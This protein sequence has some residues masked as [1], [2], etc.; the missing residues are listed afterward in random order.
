MAQAG[1]GRVDGAQ[2]TLPET[3]AQVHVYLGSA[4]AAPSLPEAVRTSDAPNG[5]KWI[6]NDRVRLLLGP[7]GAHVYRWQVKALE[8]RD[9]TQPGQQNWAGFADVPHDHRNLSNTLTCTSRGPALVQYEC[10]DETGLVKTINLFADDMEANQ[11]WTVGGPDDNATTGIWERTDPN[12]TEA[13]PEDDHSPTGINCFVT[14][15]RGGGG[16]DHDVDGGQTTLTSPLL[17]LTSFGTVVLRY[18]RW[19]SND[20]GSATDDYWQ[21][22]VTDDGST[23]VPLENTAQSNRSWLYREFD[24]G[25]FADLTNQVQVFRIIH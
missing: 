6:E 12:R 1:V 8:G 22:D 4:D 20:T 21:V 5:M 10:R 24:L 9:L 3:Q 25:D 19:Y 14:D 13:Q 16:G 17:D 7:E 23:W 2:T 18:Y 15:G 11:G